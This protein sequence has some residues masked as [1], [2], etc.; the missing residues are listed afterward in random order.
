MSTARSPHGT[1][2][3]I[4]HTLRHL[5]GVPVLVLS[6]DGELVGRHGDDALTLVGEAFGNGARWVAIPCERIDASFFDLSTRIAG[7]IVQKLTN[8]GL[9]L[10]VVGEIAE[11]TAASESLRAL[12]HESN[13]GRHLWFV[14]D[15]DELEGR[16][17][18]IDSGS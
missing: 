10:A 13:R 18:R 1:E 16:L 17:V 3:A 9:G 2:H 4:T 14:A 15:L 7:E 11:K 8:Y 5:G 6:A 12:V